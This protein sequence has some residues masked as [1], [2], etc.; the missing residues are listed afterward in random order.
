M[1]RPNAINELRTPVKLLIPTTTKYN[2]VVTKTYPADS[3]ILLFVNW[4]TFGGTET[5]VNGVISIVDTAEI[6]TWF[7]PD[8]TANC[9]LLREDGKIYEIISD[10]ENCD[11][12]NQFC[13]FKVERVKGGA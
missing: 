4:K 2:G 9:R 8:I 13:E 6:T 1:Y 3:D 12:G 5:T 7:R 11:M 10:P